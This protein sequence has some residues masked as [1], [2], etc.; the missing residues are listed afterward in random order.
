MQARS[1]PAAGLRIRGNPFR[2]R[3]LLR[4]AA[5]GLSGLR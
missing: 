3:T 2:D 4:L 5:T 1:I